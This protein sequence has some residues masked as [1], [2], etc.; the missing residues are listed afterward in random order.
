M[1]NVWTEPNQLLSTSIAWCTGGALGLVKK[2]SLILF[3]AGVDIVVI[4]M[5]DRLEEVDAH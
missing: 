3:F 4:Y 2:K 5:G 1:P